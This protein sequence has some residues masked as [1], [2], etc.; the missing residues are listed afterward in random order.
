[1]VVVTLVARGLCQVAAGRRLPGATPRRSWASRRA[2]VN[3]EDFIDQLFV[4][5]SHDTVLVL[6]EPRQ[7]YW[8]KVYQVPLG[9]AR[10]T[11]PPAS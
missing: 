4:A 5:S 11:R 2:R 7:A 9:G 3:D 10:C 8:L 1:M 6:L